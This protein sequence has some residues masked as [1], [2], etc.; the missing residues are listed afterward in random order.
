MIDEMA[1]VFTANLDSE[2]NHVYNKA[3]IEPR[4]GQENVWTVYNDIRTALTPPGVSRVV[5]ARIALEENHF[6]V[7]TPIVHGTRRWINNQARQIADEFALGSNGPVAVSHL[8]IRRRASLGFWDV[9][10]ILCPGI[11]AFIKVCVTN[12]QDLRQL[13]DDILGISVD[14]EIPSHSPTLEPWDLES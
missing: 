6:E 8:R 3:G 4:M 2:G 14:A 13:L 1:R 7:C 9:N 11:P 10:F 12:V 5:T